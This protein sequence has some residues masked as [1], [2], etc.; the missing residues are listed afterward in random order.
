[1]Y[2]YFILDRKTEK[3]KETIKKGKGKKKVSTAKIK[4]EE[5]ARQ[6]RATY[7]KNE[8]RQTQI[9]QEKKGRI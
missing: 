6:N 8:I 2:V 9:K 5:N 1:V 7:S 3:W 4:N